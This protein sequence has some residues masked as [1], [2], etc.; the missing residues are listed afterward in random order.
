MNQKNIAGLVIN[1][2][3]ISPMLTEYC[4]DNELPLFAKNVFSLS[5][6]HGISLLSLSASSM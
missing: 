3:Q 1:V 6:L 5:P 4:N 2:G